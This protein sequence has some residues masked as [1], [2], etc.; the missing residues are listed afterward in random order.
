[1]VCTVDI[2]WQRTKH[3]GT[4]GP[5]AA[6]GGSG[7]CH[8]KRQVAAV[9]GLTRAVRNRVFEWGVR[10]AVVPSRAPTGV[11]LH[12]SYFAAAAQNSG[13]KHG[14]VKI[15]KQ[16]KHVKIFRLQHCRPGYAQLLPSLDYSVGLWLSREP[17]E[18]TSTRNA[19]SLGL[20]GPRPCLNCVCERAAA[21]SAVSDTGVT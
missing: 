20:V 8:T 7:G 14:N 5:N 9:D 18:R 4:S 17:Q 1:M 21:H 15:E 19:P 13:R 2:G 12:V 11:N 16:N 10:K 6:R 3:P